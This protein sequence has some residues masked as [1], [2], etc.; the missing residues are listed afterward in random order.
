MLRAKADKCRH[1]A[2]GAD[3]RTRDNLL[4]LARSYEAEADK[5]EPPDPAHG[6]SQRR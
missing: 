1:V 4:M 6:A 3:D 2:K 5:L